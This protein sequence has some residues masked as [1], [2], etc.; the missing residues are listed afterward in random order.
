MGVLKATGYKLSTPCA[1]CGG[2]LSLRKSIY[3][4]YYA[5]D[6]TGCPGTIDAHQDTRLPVGVPGTL[7]VKALRSKGHVLMGQLIEDRSMSKG[8][9]YCWLSENMGI[10]PEES[11]FGMFGKDQC[12]RAIAL[13]EQAIAGE[14]E[15]PVEKY[16]AGMMG[17]KYYTP[18]TTKAI[19][20]RNAKRIKQG[21]NPR[22]K[23]DKE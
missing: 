22:W 17:R 14:I 8:R 4:Y 11:H 19:S 23:R 16:A 20:K 9:F 13:T 3:G 5:C 6:Q 1:I 10:K 7:E 18:N 21:R 15:G 12:L 2:C